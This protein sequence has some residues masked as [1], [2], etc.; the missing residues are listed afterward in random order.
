MSTTVTQPSGDPAT[1]Q[2]APTPAVPDAQAPATA[3][4][5]GDQPQGGDEPLGESGKKAL[6]AEREARKKAE[7]E[8]ARIRKEIEDS[9]KSA[10]Q[11]AAEELE[12]ARR[13]AQENAA[14]A[15]RYE[16]AAAKGLDL[17]LAPRLTGTTREELEADAEALKALIPTKTTPAPDPKDP[18][19]PTVGITPTLSGNVSIDDQIAA[20]EKAGNADLVKTLKAMKLGEVAT[21]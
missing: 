13:L 8:L 10:E 16:V 2:P 20:A 21:A 9:K 7:A 6:E 19:V 14:K 3:P 15:L 12:E 18:P 1:A 4:T 5:A 17:A 11:K